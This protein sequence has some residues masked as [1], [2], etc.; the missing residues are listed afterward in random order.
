M[1]V[2]DEQR[3]IGWFASDRNQPAGKVIIYTFVPNQVKNV[4]RSEDKEY[5]RSLAQL[6]VF[7]KGVASV[8]SQKTIAVTPK[9]EISKREEFVINDSVVYLS[10]DQFHTEEI[11]KAFVE[12]QEL[13]NICDKMKIELELKRTMYSTIENESDKKQLSE[14]IADMEIRLIKTMQLI[15]EKETFIRN[16]ENK[17]LIGN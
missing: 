4:A 8:Q 12:Y 13:K 11:R 9:K 15:S 14:T 16:A 1:M 17:V 2:I 7:R 6:K 5:L 3:Q 10:A